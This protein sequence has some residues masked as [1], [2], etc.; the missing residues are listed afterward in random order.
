ML[1]F[2][3]MQQQ[4]NAEFPQHQVRLHQDQV[5]C[6]RQTGNRHA[7]QALVLLHGISSGAASWLAVALHV[8]RLC[9]HSRVLAW[10]MPGYGDST[11][12]PHST[13]S[14]IDYAQVLAQSLTQLNVQRCV[15]VGHSLGALIA[16][17]YASNSPPKCISNLVLISPAGGYGANVQ[18]RK[19]VQVREQ[20]LAALQEKGIHGLAAVIDQRLAAP[21]TPEALRQWLRWNTSR[22]QAQGYAQA[23]ELL[24]GSTLGKNRAQLAMP[25]RVWVGEQDIVTQPVACKRWATK[26]AAQYTVI[27]DAGH[28]VTVEKAEVV[29]RKLAHLLE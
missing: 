14:V 1:S 20:R 17:Y 5:V 23:V 22:I 27:A 24:C 2:E 7:K 19:R 4:L 29:A 26:L 12:L 28:T 3:H 13:P 8:Q 10:D 16:T 21:N 6:W 18:A 15:L 25:I 11:P 9:P